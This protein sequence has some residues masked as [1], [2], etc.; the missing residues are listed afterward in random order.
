MR[1]TIIDQLRDALNASAE[2]QLSIAR[3]TGISQPQLSR[4]AA[5]ERMLTLENAAVLAAF[6]KLKLVRR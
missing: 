3:E 4:F 6:L 5:G 2:S 1:K